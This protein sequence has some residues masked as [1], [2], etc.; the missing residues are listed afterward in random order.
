MAKKKSTRKR[1]ARKKVA[2]KRAP[3][4]KA[5]KRKVTR[6]RAVNPNEPVDVLCNCGWGVSNIPLGRAPAACPECGEGI[7]GQPQLPNPRGKI[8]HEVYGDVHKC[9]VCRRGYNYYDSDSYKA[10]EYCGTRCELIAEPDRPVHGEPS[11]TTLAYESEWDPGLER[12][13][14]EREGYSFN[15]NRHNPGAVRKFLGRVFGRP[16]KPPVRASRS[17]PPVAMPRPPSRPPMART[18]HGMTAPGPYWRGAPRPRRNHVPESEDLLCGYD[19]ECDSFGEGFP[20]SSVPESCGWCGGKNLLYECGCDCG[21]F[22]RNVPFN[23][24]PRSCPKCGRGSI[25]RR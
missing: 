6:R 17:R 13:I 14:R 22:V 20:A 25:D 16:A 2:K 15:P 4:K 9:V 24:V 7:G 21:W 18:S 5:A 3:R 19:C 1:T 11:D 12:S 23:A 10:T 8:R